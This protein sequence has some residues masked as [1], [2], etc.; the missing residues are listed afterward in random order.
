MKK[1]LVFIISVT[2]LCSC[3]F[4]DEDFQVQAK[5]RTMEMDVEAFK[6]YMSID[7]GF[8]CVLPQRNLSSWLINIKRWPPPIVIR[9]G[10]HIFVI[11]K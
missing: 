8:F 5:P 9:I 4:S 3:Q 2:A 10:M 7:T 11:L 6:K 1:I